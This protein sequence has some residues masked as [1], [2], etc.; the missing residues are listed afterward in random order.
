MSVG[1]ALPWRMTERGVTIALRV[2]PRGGDDVIDGV[3]MQSD[4]RSALRVRVRAVAE[5]GAAN[6]AV[7]ALLARSLGLSKSDIRILSGATARLKQFSIEG[8]P[9]DLAKKLE[10]LSAG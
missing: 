8:D 10:A 1:E 3:G 5:D 9:Q 7:V 2:T 4:G 6:K